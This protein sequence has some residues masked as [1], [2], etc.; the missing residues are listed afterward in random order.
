[1]MTVA[2]M[3]SFFVNLKENGRKTRFSIVA[4]EPKVIFRCILYFTIIIECATPYSYLDLG[5]TDDNTLEH[6]C[7]QHNTC[8][9][10]THSRQ[11]LIIKL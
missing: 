11:K 8:M 4:K 9:Q 2:E 1:M 10:A 3:E 7:I 5:I 6:L